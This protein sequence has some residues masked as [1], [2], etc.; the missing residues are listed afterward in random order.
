MSTQK[1]FSAIKKKPGYILGNYLKFTGIIP[2][3]AYI[4]VWFPTQ[5]NKKRTFKTNW[6]EEE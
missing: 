6:K 3:S 4:Q 1:S 2:I 5:T